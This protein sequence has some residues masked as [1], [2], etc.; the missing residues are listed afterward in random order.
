[1][2]LRST[3]QLF[4]TYV[5]LIALV[6][7][8]LSFGIET[9]LRR[10]LNAIAAEDLRRELFLGRSLYENLPDAPP[11]SLASY[12]GE[13]SG[14]RVTIVAPDGSVIGDSR[15]PGP[16]LPVIENHLDRAEIRDAFAGQIGYALRESPTVGDEHLYLAVRTAR[17]DVIRFAFPT[18]EL[19]ATVGRVQRTIVVVGLAALVLALVF[20]F[21]FSY[22]LTR[23]IRAIGGV[24][25]DISQGDLSRRVGRGDGDE[26]GDLGNA[27]DALADELQRRLV[28][29]EDERAEMQALIDSMAEAVLAFDADGVVRRANPAAA[30][31]F[32]LPADPRG[33]PADAV[34]RRPEFLR[35]VRRAVGGESVPPTELS[36][37]NRQLLA[38][39]HPLPAGGAVVVFLDVSELRRLEGVRRDFVA[40]ASHELKTP[41]TAIRG[42]SETLLD[43]ELPPGLRRQFAETLKTNAD[44]LQRIIDDLLDLSRLESGRFQ[45]DP[46]EVDLAAAARD[47][48]SSVER[49]ADGKAVRFVLDVPDGCATFRA[50]PGALEQIL[51]NLFNNAF[52]Y[53]PQGG[54]VTLRARCLAPEGGRGGDSE[55]GAPG[56]DQ[57][58]VVEV[59]DSGSGIAAQHLPRVFE[60]FYR[61]DPARSRVEGGTGLGL[62]IVKHLVEAHGGQVE[63]ESELGVGTTVRLIFPG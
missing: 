41:L 46:D 2:R 50:D 48:W 9:M 39:A 58:V 22:A 10:Q 34:A 8:A 1:V 63:A 36:H 45:V 32:S 51:T 12:L 38:G 23:R 56:R 17:N 4:L 15:V 60:R 44:R 33:M 43:E 3:Q 7:A 35:L 49:A 19:R 11:D 61:V 6:V 26:L 57:R 18:V 47:A 5:L 25:R 59:E 16:E 20:S 28:Q 31:F 27:L 52:R 30:S 13:L 14:R 29:L 62:A 42:Y 24:A 37:D 21:L 55:A 53:T 54:S 40:N